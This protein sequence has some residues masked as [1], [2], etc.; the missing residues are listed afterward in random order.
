M[1]QQILP[2]MFM[3]QSQTPL[4]TASVMA[5]ALLDYLPK[6]LQMFSLGWLEHGL[7]RLFRCMIWTLFVS[8]LAI[9]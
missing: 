6:H 1:M 4:N 5:Q 7:D 3:S 8:I 9:T 2:M